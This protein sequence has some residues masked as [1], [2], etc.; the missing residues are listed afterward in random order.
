MSALHRPAGSLSD[1]TDPV[2]LT[3]DAAG[4]AYT[5]LRVLRLAP[6]VARAVRTGEY[7]AFVLPLA[8]SCTVRVD[9]QVFELAG[10]D[11]VFTR[12]TDFAYVP[13]DAEVE[14]ISAAGAEIALPMA[15]CTRRLEPRYGPAEGVPVEVRGGGQASRQVTNFGAPGAWEHA[16]KLNACELITPDGNWSSYPPHKHDEASECEVVNEEIYYFRIAG[17]DGITP[18]PEGFGLHR[19]YTA[20]GELDENVAVRDGDV[21]LVPRG[22]HGPCIA[23]PGYPMYYL[24]VLAGPADERS[25]AFCDDPAH[26]WVR[27]T[28]AE[29]PTDPRCPVTDHRGRAQ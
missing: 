12:V 28:W 21:F 26:G 23:A 2:L 3:A 15:R 27:D 14:L 18:G 20:D 5:G 10:R 6:G 1:G 11:S 4:W 16:D 17:R 9:G 19:T 29:Q 7:E 25:M 13:R 22:Y 8:G 24:N